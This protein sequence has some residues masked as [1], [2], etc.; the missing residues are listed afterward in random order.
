[1]A[2]RQKPNEGQQKQAGINL[3]R[4]IALREISKLSVVSLLADFAM[5]PCAK[6]LPL[7]HGRNELIFGGALDRAIEGDPGH[8]LR[9]R[10]MLA[11][12]S[13]LPDAFV[14]LLP[15]GFQVLEEFHLQC[16]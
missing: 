2:G 15:N 7:F 1:I 10:K 5:Y 8:D 4:A 9:E 16:P 6:F 3:A 13:D 14:R 12:T 11:R